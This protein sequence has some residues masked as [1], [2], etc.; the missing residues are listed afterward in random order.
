MSVG[1]ANA[2]NPAVKRILREYAEFQQSY[3]AHRRQQSSASTPSS[4]DVV[5]A[6]LSDNLF[7]WHFTLRG[8]TGT[9]YA[10][11]LYHGRVLLPSN[12]PFRPPDVVL[13]TP[14]GR[15]DVHKKICLSISSFHPANWQP[16]W[17]IRTVL[18]AL[19]AFFPTPAAGAIGSLEYTDGE[20]VALAGKSPHFVCPQCQVSNAELVRRQERGEEEEEEAV[21]GRAARQAQLSSAAPASDGAEEEEEVGPVGV[22][23]AVAVA[24]SSAVPPVA[25]SASPPSSA[26]APSSVSLPSS[27]S[28]SPPSP[29]ASVV[30]SVPPNPSSAAAAAPPLAA[31]VPSV[32]S[33]AV[34]APAPA[35][36][37]VTAAPSS[38][39]P[40]RLSR[41]TVFLS[42]LILALLLRKLLAHLL[43][44]QQQQHSIHL[45]NAR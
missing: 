20:K 24:D 33:P 30:S 32:V 16:S 38:T 40:G 8:P 39:P 29:A 10:S 2:S 21:E 28:S 12:Y 37:A 6:P 18:T 42:L 27:L 4:L 23:V 41:L 43:A 3:A 31:P 9:P 36:V 19:M 34:P 26:A 11:G 1:Q 7:E 25:S 45:F 13:L 5:A 15:F 14:S 22:A 44:H 17:S 35:A